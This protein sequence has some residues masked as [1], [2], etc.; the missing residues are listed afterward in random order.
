MQFERQS[1]RASQ[2]NLTPLI[3]V[4]FLL[5]VFFMLSTS[6]VMSESMELLLPSSHAKS[7][8]TDEVME[9]RVKP[10]GTVLM[11]DRVFDMNALD[12]EIRDVLKTHP[13]QKI[14][15]LSTDGVKVQELVTVMDLIYVNGGRNVQIDHHYNGKGPNLG[16]DVQLAE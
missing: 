3:D 6:F 5:I 15:L 1:R 11:Q 2:I 14:L 13:D 12:R 7:V 9:M 4:V 16:H 10:D 8:T